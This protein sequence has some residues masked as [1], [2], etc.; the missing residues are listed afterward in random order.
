MEE[1]ALVLNEI[2]PLRKISEDGNVS[3]VGI[4]QIEAWEAFLVSAIGA[5]VE[6]DALKARIVQ[7]VLFSPELPVDFNEQQLRAVFHQAHGRLRQCEGR[8]FRVV[9][10]IW[11]KP[12]FLHGVLSRTDATINFT[13]SLSSKRNIRINNERTNQR[14]NKQFAKFFT[15][16]HLSDLAKC[17]TCIVLVDAISPEDA[18]ERASNALYELL[19]LVNIAN[20]GAKRWRRSSR[21]S[22][23]L[24]VSDVLIGPHTTTHFDNGQLTHDGF[25]HED[26]VGGPP[27]LNLDE[28]KETNWGKR[29]EQLSRGLSRSP[30]VRDSKS[31]ATHYFKA[32]SNPNLEESFLEGWRLFENIS[33]GRYEKIDT[34]IERAAHVFEEHLEYMIIGKHLALR[35]NLISHGRPI[36]TDDNETLAFQML[37]FLLPLLQRYL[38]NGHSLRNIEE[39]WE[40]LSIPASRTLRDRERQD[41]LRRVSL[42]RKAAEFR[43]ETDWP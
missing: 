1:V 9:F 33:G 39:F 19:G 41:L 2:R 40:F 16:D 22:G 32:F 27:T 18:N 6:T 10:P 37:Q 21:I 26:W 8:R 24:P 14:R 38:L 34:K 5:P 36:K 35:R 7:Q 15:D 12:K 11:N 17:N 20:D 13:P 30:W 23:K 42:L 28:T 43:E 29:F 31:A 4:G 3:L 25:W